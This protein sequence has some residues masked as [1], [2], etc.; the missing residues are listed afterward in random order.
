MVFMFVVVCVCVYMCVLYVLCVLVVVCTHVCGVYMCVCCGVYT[1]VCCVYMC[2][3]CG[4]CVV[5]VHV[6]VV[7]VHVCC[8]VCA[9]ILCHFST[10]ITWHPPRVVPAGSGRSGRT[11]C[12]SGLHQADP[13]GDQLGSRGN[14]RERRVHPQE[15]HAPGCSAR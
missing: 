6:C 13:P 12:L 3:C 1:C 7:C 11:G 4:V 2:V 15:A 14:V 10:L 5:C 8:G 9:S